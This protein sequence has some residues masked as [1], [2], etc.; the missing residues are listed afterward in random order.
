ILMTTPLPSINHAYSLL[1]QEEKQREIQVAQHPLDSAFL[2]TKQQ[3]G[4]QK[5]AQA[6]KRRNFE[7]KRNAVVCSYCK[8]PGHSVKKC[9]RII[10]FPAN[11]YFK[12][13]KRFE[14]SIQGHAAAIADPNSD[15]PT[16]CLEKGFIQEQY[17]NLCPLLQQAKFTPQGDITSEVNVTANCGGIPKHSFSKIAN[18]IIW[19]LDSGASEHMTCDF[20][21]LFNV[22]TLIKPVFVNLPNSQRV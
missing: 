18:T 9:Y 3:Y 5:Y 20:N 19:I 4:G 12:K 16:Y 21:L 6:D 10:G 22:R 1:I 17:H 8:K 15:Q 14:G 2:A 7:G 11:F 13:N